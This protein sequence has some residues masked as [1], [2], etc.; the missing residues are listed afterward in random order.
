MAKFIG[1]E[2]EL[3]RLQQ[4]TKKRV[5]SF[6]VVKGR[7]RIGKS[8]LIKEF[9]KNFNNFYHFTG[10]VPEKHTTTTH[11]LTEFSRQIA[12]QFKSSHANYSSWGDALYS[13]GE[14]LQS[15]KILL[16]F[17]EISWMGSKDISFLGNLKNFWDLQLKTNDKLI[18]VICGSASSW[19]EKNILHSTGFVGRIS[20]T[21]TLDELP[22]A[23]CNKF[24]PKNISA[25]EKF[26]IFSVTG[27]VPKYLE[28]INPKLSAEANIKELCFTKGGIL[29]EEFNQIFSDVFLRNS[30]YYKKIIDILASGS[31][32][33]SFIKSSLKQGRTSEYLEELGSLGFI[34]KDN[35]WNLKT[36]QD[37]TSSQY[38]L[39]DNYLR[40]YLKYIEKNL[41]KIN[42]DAFALKSLIALPEWHSIMGFQFEN[43]ILNNRKK[44]HEILRIFPEDIICENPFF[45]RKTNRVKGC[46]IDYM[47]KTKFGTLYVCEIKFSHDKIGCWVIDEI[48]A[49][50]D[51]LKHYQ[52]HSYRPVLLQVNG[53][54]QELIDRDYFAEI[55]DLEQLLN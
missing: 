33:Q 44:I 28:E 4:L 51:A 46:Q 36:G 29:A 41:S 53:V 34:T 9:G 47:I 12:E 40:F 18:F 31:K 32:E 49:K 21:L 17:D 10:I 45:Q 37:L 2:K 48:Q 7:R 43:L 52:G 54:T 13:V 42:R 1:R 15:G 16:L 3:E 19:I 23:D 11:Q 14:R 22:L 25:Y 39:S 8:S 5:A 20:F 26:K 55:I 27:G 35:T 24:W 6:I 50:I 38:R 30:I